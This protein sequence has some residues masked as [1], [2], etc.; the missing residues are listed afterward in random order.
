MS[1]FIQSAILVISYGIFSAS[2]E[3]N[4]HLLHV[5]DIHSRFEQTNKRSGTCK[6]DDA[7]EEKCF[8]GVARLKKKVDDLKAQYDNVIFVNAG[9]FYQGTVFYTTFKWKVVSEFAQML[10]FTAM[11]LGNHEFD[12]GI[13][14]LLPFLKNTSTTFPMIS[15][16]ID[17][18]QLPV[19]QKLTDYIKKSTIATINGKK[20]GIIGYVTTKTAEI[21]QPPENLEFLDE[22]ESIQKEAKKLTDSGVN[23]IIAVGH[24][25]F[26][27]DKEIAEK[28][29]Q[30]DVVVGGHSNTFLYTGDPPVP[31]EKNGDYPFVVTQ[32]GG[33]QV[34]VVQAFAYTKYLGHLNLTFDDNGN[35]NNFNG[36]PILLTQNFPED[37]D[38]LKAL[39]PFQEKVEILKKT[40]VGTIETTLEHSRTQESSFGNFV[41]DAFVQYHTNKRNTSAIAIIN[42]GA[43][44]ADEISGQITRADLLQIDPFENNVEFLEIKGSIL[45]TEFE[46]SAKLLTPENELDPDG[47]FL[48][49]SG[50]RM[51]ID[52]CKNPNEITELKIKS[53]SGQ[54]IDLEDTKTYNVVTISY[55]ANKLRKRHTEISQTEPEDL[56]TDVLTEYIEN[57]CPTESK[58][59]K[60]INIISCN[61]TVI[62]PD[63][64][65][66]EST[67]GIVYLCV[68]H[69]TTKSKSSVGIVFG[70]V[71]SILVVGAIGFLL[72]KKWK[73][74]KN[75]KQPAGHNNQNFQI[76]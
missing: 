13:A 37:Q 23:I 12:D 18:S 58:K 43:I 36:N 35:L 56:E 19:E 16:N 1:P 47:A 75:S 25:G 5:N 24:A 34:P 39:E 22:I 60:R 73:S 15:S 48:Q 51:T 33:K 63:M 53:E 40:V 8:G 20:I 27:K 9:D 74:G 49:V 2:A 70:V 14:G 45:R 4:L 59:Q 61:Q 67:K 21:S 71:A 44:R 65:S 57:R 66:E 11:S 29:P 68:P 55:L 10:N 28:V 42:S 32:S 76:E 31:Q 6:P 17:D 50:I 54:Y 52:K 26:V 69:D 3:F 7:A 62:E 30:V 46:K 41:T 72:F 38:V 64:V